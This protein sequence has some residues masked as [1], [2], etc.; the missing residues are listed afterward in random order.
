MNKLRRL[1]HALGFHDWDNTEDGFFPPT[2]PVRTC[3]LCP[4]TQR[5]EPKLFHLAMLT[6]SPM[7]KWR[8]QS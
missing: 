7:G 4:K 5:W 8:N 2:N 3:K 1:A 6:D